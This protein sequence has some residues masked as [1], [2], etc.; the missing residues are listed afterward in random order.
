MCKNKT[1]KLSF[2]RRV[3]GLPPLLVGSL[4]SWDFVVHVDLSWVWDPPAQAGHSWWYKKPLC[5][6]PGKSSLGRAQDGSLWSFHRE[7]GWVSLLKI[8]RGLI[9]TVVLQ[10]QPCPALV[11]LQSQAGSVW[12]NLKP[13]VE[14][15]RLVACNEGNK[16]FWW[17]M[18][19][20]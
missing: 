6:P 4:F 20:S 19:V 17:Q 11:K 16:F 7:E 3:W 8:S 2:L 12:E 13:G 5:N 14:G 1:R 18:V 10:M 9:W 15:R